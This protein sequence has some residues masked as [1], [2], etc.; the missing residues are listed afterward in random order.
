M[1][2]YKKSIF[3]FTRDLRLFDNTVLINALKSSEH[4]LPIF[5]L[6]PS[7]LGKDNEYKSDNCV[8]F[9]MECL[10]DLDKE[11]K[12]KKSKLFLFYGETIKIL[13]KL[14]KSDKTYESI[15]ITKDYTP[16]A[17]QRE[18]D[19]KKLCDKKNIN[20]FTEEDHM[21]L[22][23]NKVLNMSGN[24]YMKFTPFFKSALQFKVNKPVE[25]NYTN[26]VN[27]KTVYDFEFDEE[28]S[29]FYKYNPDLWVNG[30]RNNG[31]KYL[32]KIKNLKE[33]STSRDF[34]IEET[35]NLSAFLKFNVISVREVYWEIVKKLGSKTKLLSQLYWRDFYMSIMSNFNVINNNMNNY[36][37][38]WKGKSSD[39]KAWME[40]KTGFP[41]VD[42]GMRQLNKTGYMHN[43]VRMVVA[44][45]L[46]KILHFDWKVGEKYFA[47]K[48]V[49]YDPANN[50]GGWQWVAGTGT[51]SQPYFRYL[52]PWSQALS[53]DKECVYIKKYVE[54]LKDVSPKDI[55]KWNDQTT[56]EKYD[57]DYPEP[58]Y[59][60]VTEKIKEAIKMYK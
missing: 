5:V 53:Y 32:L 45:F 12:K 3:V 14:L 13:T 1:P 18:T 24:T 37:V 30:G 8:Q 46:V 39:L 60:N 33:Y 27:N 42:A 38:K 28:L 9:M 59:E 19:I 20:F 16:Y 47:T 50:N 25:N 29:K 52:N 36:N 49:D 51:D 57:I 44:S 34:P 17:K 6:N 41:I 11:L 35:T 23:E 58:I 40:G 15:Y 56:R 22:G 7:Q 21:L 31:L 43:R 26:Y 48:L 10:E 2:K 55:L 4:V 54:E